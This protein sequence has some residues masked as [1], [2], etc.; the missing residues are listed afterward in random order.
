[1]DKLIAEFARK[2]S[3]GK[4]E[5][6]FLLKEKLRGEHHQEELLDLL[7][8]EFIEEIGKVCEHRDV[9]LGTPKPPIAAGRESRPATSL[10]QSGARGAAVAEDSLLE[11]KMCDL[12]DEYV[13]PE[14]P[15]CPSIEKRVQV[16]EVSPEFRYVFEE[17]KEFNVL[18]S[19]VFHTIYGTDENCLVSA[20]TGAG[21]TD[22]ALLA[23]LRMLRADPGAKA[24]YIA[25]MKALAA[26]IS[27]KFKSRLKGVGVSEHTGDTSLTGEEIA[28][29][30][31][32]VCTPE[33][34]DATSRRLTAPIFK[35]LSLIVIDEVH[36]LN[37]ARGPVLES[38]VC[39]VHGAIER[40]QRMVRI[41][42][43]SATLP[44]PGDVAQFLWVKPERVH[45]FGKEY[46][47]VPLRCSV[48]GVRK[49]VEVAEP[50]EEERKRR[51]DQKEKI[52]LV[53]EE[54]VLAFVRKGEQVLI[55]VHSRAETVSTAKHLLDTLDLPLEFGRSGLGALSQAEQQGG[56][57]LSGVLQTLHENGLFV[58]HAGLPRDMRSFAEREF[59]EQR[60]RILVCTST[61]AWGV[62]L[63][64]HAVIIKGTEFYSPD[65]GKVEEISA[66][67]VQQMFGRAGRPQFDRRGE[68]L[69]ITGHS[70]LPKYIRLLRS[71]RPIESAMLFSL[72]NHLNSEICLWNIACVGA[73]E[74]WLKNTY[75]WIRMNRFPEK[76]GTTKSDLRHAL[77]DYLVLS[78]ERLRRIGCIRI[79]RGLHEIEEPAPA[80]E[81]LD[82]IPPQALKKYEDPAV[83]FEPTELGR[84]SAH[85]CLGEHTIIAWLE[86][87]RRGGREALKFFVLSEEFAHMTVRGEEV[88]ELKRLAGEDVPAES[89]GREQKIL[90]LL[91]GFFRKRKLA[92]FSLGCDRNYVIDNA[93]RILQG[94]GHFFLHSKNP[95]LAYECQCLFKKVQQQSKTAA[96]FRSGLGVR[97]RVTERLA[98]RNF[99][100][101]TFV[102]GRVSGLLVLRVNGEI[103]VMETL[104]ES[105]EFALPLETLA[106][107]GSRPSLQV[108]LIDPKRAFLGRREILPV[109]K[110]SDVELWIVDEQSYMAN[111]FAVEVAHPASHAPER[112]GFAIRGSVHYKAVPE[113]GSDEFRA[114]T[115]LQIY[116]LVTHLRGER[117]AARK[118][119]A[120]VVVPTEREGALLLEELGRL[121]AVEGA[122]FG[123]NKRS[124]RI[125]FGGWAICVSASARPR[126]GAQ[127]AKDVVIFRGFTG[128]GE[129]YPLSRIAEAGGAETVVFERR[130]VLEYLKANTE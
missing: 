16:S 55:F 68:A 42:G 124:S 1:M 45:V 75:M 25:P 114:L 11:R 110:I 107:K 117:G 71:E 27:H 121:G 6:E 30:T 90:L 112:E 125:D 81:S 89:I 7:G 101:V 47:P 22:V 105:R 24:V 59:K 120:E 77:R 56:Q 10:K 70:S 3:V 49:R 52:D 28:R 76:Y 64:A 94:L 108:T 72:V 58:H 44:N 21:K 53:L 26:E 36:L 40:F 97:M 115:T 98:H 17:Y 128:G 20:P 60:V 87:Y 41:V 39:R 103:A 95:S 104:R 46:R 67:D 123:L 50:G 130:A 54:R 113:V 91:D 83:H 82:V 19:L 109:R 18:Q 69:L 78:I 48:I 8:P 33:K 88:K 51:L 4:K 122:S 126:G 85:Y 73:G 5:A 57:K 23:V 100:Q 38:I 35:C 63:P 102:G 31:V 34:F 119:Q 12:Y 14:T 111:G 62:N 61:L 106:E 74:Y 43:L 129:V 86:L 116:S 79:F 92:T 80:Q 84:I 15:E 65:R 96:E 13:F 29:A 93:G 99:V 32:L 37:D 127:E 118:F 9:F 2:F 66:L